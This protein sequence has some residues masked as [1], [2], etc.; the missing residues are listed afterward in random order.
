MLL[1]EQE[2]IKE[3]LALSVKFGGTKS[4]TESPSGEQESSTNPFSERLE[5]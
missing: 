2:V 5:G 3:E 4:A 1:V